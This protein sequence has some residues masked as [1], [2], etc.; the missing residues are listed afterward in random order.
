MKGKKSSYVVVGTIALVKLLSGGADAKAEPNDGLMVLESFVYHHPSN[1]ECIVEHLP[2]NNY[3]GVSEGW[4]GYDQSANECE[5]NKSS[6][7]SLIG[8]GRAWT[9]AQP[10]DCNNFKIEVIYNGTITEGN[11][12]NIVLE[13]SLPYPN[14]IFGNRSMILMQQDANGVDIETGYRGDAR[15]EINYGGGLAS[16]NFGKLPAG[17]YTPGTPFLHLRL[18]FDKLIADLDGKDIVNLKDYAILT[19]YWNHEGRCI[20]D[21]YG[22]NGV[23]DLIV[24]NYDL[25][26]MAEQWLHSS[27]SN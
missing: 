14:Y 4:D 12:P 24:D 27:L 17:T 1:N 16:I 3:P 6:T 7:H 9:N 20:A 23:P 13:F 11:E 15:A 25:A 21:M 19:K 5:P 10:T 26:K 22:P 18:D 8:G 2:P